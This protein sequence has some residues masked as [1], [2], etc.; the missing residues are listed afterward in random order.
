M[1]DD[2][3]VGYVPDYYPLPNGHLGK[4]VPKVPDYVTAE[5]PDYVVSDSHSYNGEANE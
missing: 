2:K 1:A 5:T 4:D 3:K